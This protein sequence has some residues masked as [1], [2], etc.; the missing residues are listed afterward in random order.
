MCLCAHNAQKSVSS[1]MFP[2]KNTQF[3]MNVFVCVYVCVY[4]WVRSKPQRV[5]LMWPLPSFLLATTDLCVCVC[6]YV[7]VC[8][9]CPYG[10]IPCVLLAHTEFSMR[11]CV[12]VRERER[13]SVCV[14]VCVCGVCVYVCVC[15]HAMPLR[16]Y[17]MCPVGTY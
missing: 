6:M 1:N 4:M 5:S 16:V 14:C 13:A 12:C 10:C 3:F 15:L 2:V 17:P 7:Y 11:V 8:T 9:Q